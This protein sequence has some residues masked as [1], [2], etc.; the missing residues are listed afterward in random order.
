MPGFQGKVLPLICIV[1]ALIFSCAEHEENDQSATLQRANLDGSNVEILFAS[2]L[3]ALGSL[4]LD[5]EANKIYWVNDVAHKIQRVNL[6]GSDIE[7]LVTTGRWAH[8]I[9][10]DAVGAKIYWIDHNKIQRAN[11]D[12][13]NVEA[14]VKTNE[15]EFPESVVLDVEN[16]KMYWT[17][18]E[19]AGGVDVLWFQIQRANLDGSNVEDLVAMEN[20]DYPA[21]IVTDDR[22]YW[23]D[24]DKI[25]R[26]N[27]DGSNVE[28]FISEKLMTPRDFALDLTGD[29]IYWL[30]PERHPEDS[31]KIPERIRRA[32]LDG[33]NVEV[34]ISVESTA[35][36]GLFLDLTGG[37]IYWLE[38]TYRL[39]GNVGRIRRANLDGSNVEY[40]ISEELGVLGGVT[41]DFTGGKI[42][43]TVHIE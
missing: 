33:S 13:S 20:W 42:Y 37:K 17:L 36:W 12:G 15:L 9:T 27:L 43:W 22:I 8:G 39:N 11:L 25:R 30:T 35:L 38:T 26:A 14:L 41:F 4:T 21:L 32:N 29:K 19:E 34:L 23:T 6:D 40:L 28:D 18:W 24:S 2:E 16:G 31:S 1:C 7:E 10:L 3:G 5:L